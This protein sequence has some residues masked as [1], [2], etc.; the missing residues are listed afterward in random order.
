MQLPKKT[1]R[2]FFYTGFASVILNRV[3]DQTAANLGL[4][5]I[6]DLPLM[7]V[8]FVLLLIR[9][10]GVLLGVEIKRA[11]LASFLL[12]LSSISYF[13][14]GQSY[15]P[16]ACLLLCGIGEVNVKRVIKVASACIL[17]L[18]VTLGL[19]QVIE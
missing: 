2:A 11:A 10:V 4:E 16:T 17:T 3:V 8:A 14:C 18:I 5:F 1:T 15:L 9:Y 19:L 7:P 6:L 12:L 13:K